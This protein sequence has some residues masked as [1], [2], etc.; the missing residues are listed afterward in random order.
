[1]VQSERRG[2]FTVSIGTGRQQRGEDNALGPCYRQ[3]LALS[4]KHTPAAIARTPGSLRTE[5]SCISA[6]SETCGPRHLWH[7]VT[8]SG[9]GFAQLPSQADSITDSPYPGVVAQRLR[10]QWALRI[11]IG[12]VH[13]ALGSCSGCPEHLKAEYKTSLLKPGLAG[14]LPARMALR[15]HQASTPCT[16]CL[17]TVSRSMEDASVWGGDLSGTAR[18]GTSSGSP[19]STHMVIHKALLICCESVKRPALRL[20]A[21]LRPHM[22]WELLCLCT[23]GYVCC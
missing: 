1:M 14:T 18:L 21:S 3:G 2:E 17:R 15:I 4:N 20:L 23:C 8:V 22:R 5:S 7:T 9:L 10:H 6:L 11:R 12:P 13:T 19:T 16:T